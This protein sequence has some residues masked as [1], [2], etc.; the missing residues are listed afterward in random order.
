MSLGS[1]TKLLH[2]Q[3]MPLPQAAISLL[4][5]ADKGAKIWHVIHQGKTKTLTEQN[6]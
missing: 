1:G 5:T 3:V 2:K 6:Y 4:K